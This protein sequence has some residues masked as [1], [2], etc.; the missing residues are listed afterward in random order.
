LAVLTGEKDVWLDPGGSGELSAL[1]LAADFSGT[2]H[3]ER[4]LA[5]AGTIEIVGGILDA[6]AQAVKADAWRQS[7]GTVFGG[8]GGLE[9]ARDAV[10]HAGELEAP[11]ALMRVGRL[12]IRRPGIV[13]MAAGGKLELTGNGE[14]LVGDGLL[15]TT[16]NRRNSIEYTGQSTTSV[17]DAGPL[18]AAHGLGLRGQSRAQLPIWPPLR[19]APDLYPVEPSST[20]G[21]FS[22]SGTLALPE[23]EWNL[24]C[25]VADATGFAYFGAG[26]LSG[27][28]V[29][30]RLSDFTRVGALTLDAGEYSPH[31]AVIDPAGGFAYFGLATSPGKVVKI[32]LSDFTKV[33]TLTFN[34]AEDIAWSAV[35]DPAGGSAYFGADYGSR[36]RVVK[37][38]LSD[39]TR[40]GSLTFNGGEGSP[41]SAVIDPVGRMAYFGTN[42]SPGSVVKVQLSDFSRVG[43]L[44]LDSGEN[45]LGSAVIDP[46]GGFAYFATGTWPGIVVRV[47][48][49]DFARVGALTLN[50]GDGV[51]NCA[52]IDPAG[53]FAYFGTGSSPGI[54]VKVR[55]SDFSRAGGLTFNAGEEQLRSAVIDPA[56][57]FAYFGTSSLVSVVKVRLSDFTRVGGLGL[58]PGEGGVGSGVVDSAGGFAYVGTSAGSRIVKV[59]LSDF[60]R[61]GALTLGPGESGPNNAA[62]DPAGGFAYFGTETPPGVV[63]K[64][65]LSDFTRVDALTLDPERG[66]TSVLIDPDTG[67]AYFGVCCGRGAVFKVR[68]SDFTRVGMLLPTSADNGVLEGAIDAAGGFAY[69][70]AYSPAKSGGLST[71]ILKVRLSDFTHVG[72]LTLDP[73]EIGVGAG[74]IDPVRGFAYFSTSKIGSAPDYRISRVL[75]KIRLANFTRVGSLTLGEGLP[76]NTVID[77]LGGFAYDGYYGYMGVTTLVKVRLS[78]FAPVASLALPWQLLGPWTDV[79]DATGGFAYLGQGSADVIVRVDLGSTTTSAAVSDA[80]SIFGRP[81][82]FTAAVSALHADTGSPSGTVT[83]SSDGAPISGCAAVALSGG[84]AQCATSALAPGEHTIEA[85][86]VADANWSNS[87]GSALQTVVTGIRRHLPHR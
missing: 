48:L 18:V 26:T 1:T 30:I 50:A 35:I 62:L 85:Q 31:S 23:R 7:G 32:R 73:G 20:T 47:R 2:L 8:S 86:F 60:T 27:I 14:P 76:M 81:V 11:S 19:S 24:E 37:V 58:D 13:R 42:D 43:A 53:G 22:V 70:G 71:N 68:L 83:F 25:G 17:T 72:T 21:G 84:Q 39:L 66:L 80:N 67:F 56:G 54:V 74:V 33:G 40:V 79:I 65:R 36:G 87:A 57:G 82:T 64:V 75:V 59:R 15:D 55:L 46:A 45:V 61:V 51:L 38:R 69:F 78:D 52:A 34:D 28:I 6:G 10:V 5:V 63:V 9:I 12:E 41:A 49:S 29:K 16:T 3:L 77:P 44:K 4:D